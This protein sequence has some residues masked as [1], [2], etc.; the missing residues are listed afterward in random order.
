M[1]KLYILLVLCFIGGCSESS[2]PA[3]PSDTDFVASLNTL[4]RSVDF[5]SNEAEI[6]ESWELEETYTGF[7]LVT[8]DLLLV[9]GYTVEKAVLIK[10]STGKQVASI[11][12][13]EGT[14]NS[15][16]YEEKIYM[17]NALDNTVSS[18]NTNGKK[19]QTHSTGNYPMAMTSDGNHLFV[20]NFKDEFLSV[21]SLDLEQRDEWAIPT[22]SHGLI[23]Q[24]NELWLGGHGAGSSPNRSIKRINIKNGELIGEIEV[25]IMPINMARAANGHIF[26]VSHGSSTVYEISESGEVLNSIKAGANPFWISSF[27]DSMVLAGYD[28]HQ[29]Y[30][31][32]SD[33]ITKKLQ[34]G[35]G[36]FQLIVREVE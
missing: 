1:K 22:S 25:P 32:Q 15:Y 5:V 12:V 27:G 11:D 26:T 7:T 17:A 8:D 19:L 10:L 35:K 9:Y 36:P 31:I 6:I 3:I 28:D 18:Y 16:V 24:D 21:L 34:V 30:F 2:F 4:G 23:I 13:G 20:V 14:T 29:L 33:E